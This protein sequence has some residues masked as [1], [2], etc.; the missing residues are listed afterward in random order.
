MSVPLRPSSR[1]I[2]ASVEARFA[3]RDVYTLVIPGPSLPEYTGDWI[4]WFSERHPSDER[5]ARVLAPIPVRKYYLTGAA[6]STGDPQEN[7]TVQL[8]SVI[9]RNG[10]VTGARILR[11][12]STGEGFRLRALEELET[13]EFQ[14]ALRNGEPIEVDAVFE[15]SLRITPSRPPADRAGAH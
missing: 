12:G 14:P 2:P 6:A 7:G 10:R 13:W 8:A 15:I 4:V 9:D 1:I 5:T 11:G 3:G